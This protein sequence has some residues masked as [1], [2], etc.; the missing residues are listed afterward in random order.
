MTKRLGRGL[1]SI[2]E[3]SP[4]QSA[5]FVSVR[6]DQIR[7]NRFQPRSNFDRGQ[8]DELKASIKK[9]G[10]LQPILIRPTGHGIYELVAGE[11]RWRAAQ[12]VGLQEIPAIIKS[13]EDRDAL[14]YSLIENVQRSDLNPLDEAAAYRRLSEE[15]GYTQEQIAAGIGKDRATIA[16]LLRLLKLPDSAQKALRDGHITMGHARALLAAEGVAKQETLL[17][18]VIQQQLSVRQLE[19]MIQRAQPARRKKQ[20]TQDPQ[21]KAFEDQLRQALG[22]KVS[23]LSRNKGGRIIIE[24]YSTEDLNRLL[25]ALGI[26]AE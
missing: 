16:N 21:A 25:Q 18:Q 8:L 9:R 23:V 14:E 13:L 5:R 17:K 7:A 22:T 3:T 15:F 11:R 6:L 4:S 19:G 2:I 12:A 1:E 26:S 24:Y 10:V 20:R